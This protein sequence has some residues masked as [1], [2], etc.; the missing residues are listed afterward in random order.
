MSHPSPGL[1]SSLGFFSIS[2]PTGSD[3][4]LVAFPSLKK[5]PLSIPIVSASNQLPTPSH[6]SPVIPHNAVSRGQDMQIRMHCLFATTSPGAMA[7][8]PRA[9]S[10]KQPRQQPCQVFCPF[11][12]HFKDSSYQFP[13]GHSTAKPMATYLGPY[14]NTAFQMT[15]FCS[16]KGKLRAVTNSPTVSMVR[17]HVGLFLTLVIAQ[18]GLA[19]ELSST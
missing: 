15:S 17:H 3:S 7:Q 4:D 8:H 6:L 10:P 2:S 9:L 13:H 14:D 12:P 18:G 19:K 1:H 11:P 5:K 16:S